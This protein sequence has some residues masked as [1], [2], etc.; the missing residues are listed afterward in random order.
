MAY[1]ITMDVAPPVKIQTNELI[2]TI[3]LL[4]VAQKGASFFVPFSE[5]KTKDVKTMKHGMERRLYMM[6][7][8]MRFK[9]VVEEN[10]ERTGI[11]IF[12]MGQK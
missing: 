8:P 2:D 10:A 9:V 5:S 11:R 6:K 3:N 4:V 12:N 1:Q 7:L